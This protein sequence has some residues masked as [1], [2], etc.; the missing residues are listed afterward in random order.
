MRGPCPG[1]AFARLV[2]QQHL[3]GLHSFSHW[4]RT[5]AADCQGWHFNLAVRCFC[6]ACREHEEVC[7]C[8]LWRP[9]RSLLSDKRQPLRSLCSLFWAHIVNEGTWWVGG[10]VGGSL[11]VVC[12]QHGTRCFVV[13]F[14]SESAHRTCRR[15]CLC[16][17]HGGVRRWRSAVHPRLSSREARWLSHCERLGELHFLVTSC[18]PNLLVIEAFDF[19]QLW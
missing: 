15:R 10:W 7:R 2:R 14:K 5:W 18:E 3:P 9:G 13:A 17:E 11:F 19:M 8:A 16:G 4:A 12:C 1:K 6:S